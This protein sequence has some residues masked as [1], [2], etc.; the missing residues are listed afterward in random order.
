[1]DPR[2][3]P[4][5]PNAGAMPPALVGRDDLLEEY[6]VLLDRLRDGHSEQSLLVTGL[7]GVGKTVLLLEFEKIAAGSSWLPIFAE[8][9]SQFEFSPRI[10]GLVRRALLQMSPRS[11]WGDRLNRAAAVLR[12]FSLTFAPDGSVT[13]GLD[14][15][16]QQGCGDSGFLDIDL[17]DLLVALGEA[18]QEK[19]VGVVFLLDEFQF[20]KAE[21]LEGLVVALHKV[22]QRNLPV[23]L[24]GAGLP[25]IPEL[26][27]KARTYAERLFRF[28]SIERLARKD[29]DA[30]LVEPAGALGMRFSAGALDRIYEYTDGYPYFL[31]EYGKMLWNRSDTGDVYG[32]DVRAAEP[33]VR[34]VLDSAFFRVRAD[35]LSPD[36]LTVL[37]GMAELGGGPIQLEKLVS[38]VSLG[39]SD[40][41][42]ILSDLTKRTMVYSPRFGFFG[43]TVPHFDSYLQRRFPFTEG[44]VVCPNELGAAPLE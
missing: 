13:G 42:A 6:R 2:Q 39:P 30:A 17:P 9:S 34:N 21:D 1:M 28:P 40:P 5:T 27:G 22:V 18:A 44:R 15:E 3:N 23:A 7:R 25:Q 36:E 19:D 8:I 26:A 41:A 35:G 24:V 12:S 4:F 33:E 29:A 11:R 16:A 43:F 37:R 14:V 20:L 32:N 10:H 38:I 31:Q